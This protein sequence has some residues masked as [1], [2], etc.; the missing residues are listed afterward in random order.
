MLIYLHGLNSSPR[1]HKA[2]ILRERMYPVPVLAP[3]YPAHRPDAAVQRL[4]SFFGSLRTE[5]D[6][7]VVGSSMGG[8]YGQYLARRFSFA[9]LFLINPALQPWNLFS[10]YV[11]KTMTTADGD[12]YTVTPGLIA[13]TRRYEIT[14]PCEGVQTTLFL[15]KDD[16]IIDYRIA[17]ALYRPCGRLR[18]FEGG[19]HAFQHLDEAIAEIREQVVS[20]KGGDTDGAR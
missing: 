5:E 7:F 16:E 14:A 8:F 4:C 6:P 13:S 12:V 10:E 20:A 11:H 1:S 2:G 15:D 18:V 9:H 19:D 17:V 3:S